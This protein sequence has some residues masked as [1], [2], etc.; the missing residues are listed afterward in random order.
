M[1]VMEQTSYLLQRCR[2]WLV[3]SWRRRWRLTRRGRFVVASLG[4]LLVFF[5]SS[6]LGSWARDPLPAKGLPA[7]GSS[8]TGSARPRGPSVRRARPVAGSP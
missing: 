2:A 7:T 4:V 3:A 6:L 8:P 1:V 5:I